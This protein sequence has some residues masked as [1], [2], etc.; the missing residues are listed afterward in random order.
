MK[1]IAYRLMLP[2]H[3]SERFFVTVN[4][5]EN[6]QIFFYHEIESNRFG[7]FCICCEIR[8][9]KLRDFA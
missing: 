5:D 3:I 4:C 2:R 6:V 7:Q 8:L 9:C 1:K